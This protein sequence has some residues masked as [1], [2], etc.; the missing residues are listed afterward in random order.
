MTIANGSRQYKFAQERECERALDLKE[1]RMLAPP[2][3]KFHWQLYTHYVVK[4]T[5]NLHIADA[6][7]AY[8]SAVTEVSGRNTS[9]WYE[10][11]LWEDEGCDDGRTGDTGCEA[12]LSSNSNRVTKVPTRVPVTRITP[13]LKKKKSIIMQRNQRRKNTHSAANRDTDFGDNIV[14]GDDDGDDAHIFD[15]KA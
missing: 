9:G 7:S 3:G 4:E 12:D 10:T 8:P 6:G 2:V 13:T 5:S 11:R 15:R 14:F 1:K